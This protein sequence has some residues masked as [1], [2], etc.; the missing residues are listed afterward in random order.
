[1]KRIHA[2]LLFT[3]LIACFIGLIVCEVWRAGRSEWTH[4]RGSHERKA[5]GRR[6]QA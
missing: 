3:Y 6:V 5:K 2:Y 4:N 1:M